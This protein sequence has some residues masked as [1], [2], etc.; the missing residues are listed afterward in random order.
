VARARKP[1]MKAGQ[2]IPLSSARAKRERAAQDANAAFAD[3][4]Q[5]L[6]PEIEIML[7]FILA[8]IE[9]DEDA[10]VIAAFTVATLTAQGVGP[11]IRTTLQQIWLVHKT[12][13]SDGG[14]G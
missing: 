1:R 14:G 9:D 10:L 5:R 4:L 3:R 7:R 13:Q 2:V 6:E 8:L 11:D 12:L